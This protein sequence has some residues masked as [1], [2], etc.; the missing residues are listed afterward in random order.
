MHP[1]VLQ[2]QIMMMRTNMQCYAKNNIHVKCKQVVDC[3]TSLELCSNL[4]L[5]RFL[6]DYAII[7]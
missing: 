6:W 2:G 1:M 7:T 5:K 4:N 3:N